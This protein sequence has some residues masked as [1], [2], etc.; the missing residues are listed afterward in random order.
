MKRS[1]SSL[2]ISLILVFASGIAVGVVGHYLYTAKSVN[3]TSLPPASADSF[4][5]QF[6]QEMRQRVALQDNQLEPIN[7]VLDQTRLQYKKVREKMKP[8]MDRIKTEQIEK[9]NA[10]LTPDQ[11]KLY[12]QLRLER[13]DKAK[14]TKTSRPP[15]P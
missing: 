15:G 8:D 3:A 11:Q 10:I 14:Q 13:E 2:F 5:K 6:V 1:L 12:E 7:A 4:R 9:I